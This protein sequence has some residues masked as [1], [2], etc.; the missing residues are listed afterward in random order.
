MLFLKSIG[1]DA[2][3]GRV[4]ADFCRF[5]PFLAIFGPFWRISREMHKAKK[6]EK[7]EVNFGTKKF[8]APYV[9]GLF[10][11]GSTTLPTTEGGPACWRTPDFHGGGS[12]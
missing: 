10:G 8:L 2:F 5:W 11:G 12:V 9:G 4:L 1:V 3:L 7:S 6:R